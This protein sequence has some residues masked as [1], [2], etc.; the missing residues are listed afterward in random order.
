MK[1]YKEFLIAHTENEL[2]LLNFNQ[3]KFNDS[4]INFLKDLT[5]ISDSNPD[6]MKQLLDMI[7]L[8][9]DF[10]PISEITELDFEPNCYK[11]RENITAFMK[12]TR[13]PYI[14]KTLDGRVWNDRAIGYKFA[15]DENSN[16]HFIYQD[17]LNS[18]QEITLPYYPSIIVKIIN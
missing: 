17:G 11:E 9:V 16:I 7:K 12:C 5:D 8:L 13:H 14:Y 18:K 4:T 6:M 1:S 15:N 3:T 2:K 10:Q